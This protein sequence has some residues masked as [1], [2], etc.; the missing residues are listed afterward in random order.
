MCGVCIF[1]TDGLER[2]NLLG[3]LNYQVELPTFYVTCV[4]LE[5]P[6]DPSGLFPSHQKWEWVLLTHSHSSLC[7]GYQSILPHSRNFFLTNLLVPAR[8]FHIAYIKDTQYVVK[9]S[10]ATDKDSLVLLNGIGNL[11]CGV[12]SIYSWRNPPSQSSAPQVFPPIPSVHT[13]LSMLCIHLILTGHVKYWIP[14]FPS[15]SQHIIL[16]YHILPLLLAFSTVGNN[17]KVCKASKMKRWGNHSL[18]GQSHRHLRVGGKV[19][20]C[21]GCANILPP[22]HC[23]GESPMQARS[24]HAILAQGSAKISV[25]LKGN[26]QPLKTQS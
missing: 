14:W 17:I 1:L 2:Q 5:I 10:S 22:Q 18:R 3:D 15:Q 8:F 25:G 20:A 26:V 4:W 9:K 12:Q 24:I 21:H 13:S 16:P 7:L 19:R 11:N 23:W 6:G